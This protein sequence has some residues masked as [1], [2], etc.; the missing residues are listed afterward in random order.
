MAWYGFSAET[1]EEQCIM[2]NSK[3]EA[4]NILGIAENS[5]LVEMKAAYK[6]LAKK[7]HPDTGNNDDVSRYYLVTEAYGYLC[8]ACRNTTSG[9]VVGK[10]VGNPNSEYK[11]WY[12]SR[13]SER[14]NYEKQYKK[15]KEQRAREF[16][17]HVEE[18]NLKQK[19]LKKQQEEYD[20]AMKAIDAIIMAEAI[21]A[22]I[23][24]K[25]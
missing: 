23:G 14:E 8:D 2:I 17:Q 6:N 20:N 22:M 16:K 21:K 25:S 5:T 3:K 18:Y 19:E 10:V 1:A 15:I 11:N 7:Y 9:K 24:S 12:S 4:C 13:K